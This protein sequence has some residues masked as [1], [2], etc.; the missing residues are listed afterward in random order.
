MPK[1]I[2]QFHFSNFSTASKK[3][4]PKLPDPEVPLSLITCCWNINGVVA[5]TVQITGGG[6][7]IT[8]LIFILLLPWLEGVILFKTAA[9]DIFNNRP[10][11]FNQFALQLGSLSCIAHVTRLLGLFYS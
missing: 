3:P 7:K 5:D 6:D 11:S 8:L 4:L 9:L 2:L 1:T 10:F